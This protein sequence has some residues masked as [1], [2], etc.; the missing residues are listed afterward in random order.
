MICAD[1]I[2]YQFFHRICHGDVLDCI[3]RVYKIV[4]SYKPN[5]DCYGWLVMVGLFCSAYSGFIP[6]GMMKL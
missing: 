6:M 2:Q 1:E 5:R 3:C 4:I